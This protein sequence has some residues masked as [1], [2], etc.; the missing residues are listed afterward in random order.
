MGFSLAGELGVLSSCGMQASHRGGF[1]C[2][3]AQVLGHMDFISCAMQAQQL[4]LMS[5][6]A[7]V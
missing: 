2:R 5:S 6:R 1:F 4:R 3:G 7:Q